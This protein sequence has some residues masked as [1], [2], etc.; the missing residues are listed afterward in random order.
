[1]SKEFEHYMR[2]RL[3][4][5][6]S[7]DQQ[8]CNSAPGSQ[9]VFVLGDEHHYAMVV[10]CASNMRV[11]LQEQVQRREANARSRYFWTL[12]FTNSDRLTE[13][14]EAVTTLLLQ[15]DPKEAISSEPEEG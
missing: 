5:P 14:K 4:G 12:I 1:M 8:G 11:A 9:G 10:D 15:S 2:R 13:L 3:H 6:Y 7:F